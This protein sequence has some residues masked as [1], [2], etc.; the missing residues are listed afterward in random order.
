MNQL[1]VDISDNGH[2]IKKE[3]IHKIFDTFF[4]TKGVGEG[5]GLG[6][7]ISNDIICKMH[8]EILV[9]S[10]YGKGSTFSVILPSFVEHKPTEESSVEESRFQKLTG[11]ILIVEDEE[12]IREILSEMLTEFGLEVDE[13]CDGEIAFQKIMKE[14]QY[15][16]VITDM[17]MPKMDGLELIMKVQEQKNNSPPFILLSGNVSREDMDDSDLVNTYLQKPFSQEEVYDA[18]VTI[19]K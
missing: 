8:G 5:T 9:D 6:L 14:S 4:T 7:G 16:I 3:N 1:V 15:D 18:L 17:Q 10:L 11:K 12:D 2:G 13:A 19:I